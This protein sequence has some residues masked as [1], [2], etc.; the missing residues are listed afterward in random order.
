MATIFGQG[1]NL[2]HE[3]KISFRLKDK[4]H[5][6]KVC[7]SME[8]FG[9]VYKDFLSRKSKSVREIRPSFSELS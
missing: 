2:S 8:I 5:S 6:A 7:N 9:K 4:E 1:G 3:D